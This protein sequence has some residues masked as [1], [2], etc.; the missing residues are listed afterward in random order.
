[1]IF[2]L[3][4]LSYGEDNVAKESDR[5]EPTSQKVESTSE[6]VELDLWYIKLLD[7]DR[8]HV[9]I[10]SLLSSTVPIMSS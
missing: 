6:E 8:G 5:S 1:M 10:T 9:L 3:P 7:S 2:C 4:L